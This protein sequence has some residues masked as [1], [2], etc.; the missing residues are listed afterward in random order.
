MVND[1]TVEIIPNREPLPINDDLLKDYGEFNYIFYPGYSE[2]KL[3]RLRNNTGADI[4][5]HIYFDRDEADGIWWKTLRIYP[6]CSGILPS[7][8][9]DTDWEGQITASGTQDLYIRSIC[10]K[11]GFSW[12]YE[13]SYWANSGFTIIDNEYINDNEEQGPAIDC[14]A[15]NAGSTLTLDT[16]TVLPLGT[17]IAE[18][19]CRIKFSVDAHVHLT[20]NIQYSDNNSTWTTVYTGADLSITDHRYQVTF[21]WPRKGAH[22]YWRIYKTNAAAAGGN[23]TEVQWLLFEAHQDAYDYGVY[24]DHRALMR[25]STNHMV[26][27]SW[28]TSV[29]VN[30]DVFSRQN[31]MKPI[32]K[33]GPRSKISARNF[34]KNGERI[35][36]YY[37]PSITFSYPLN[38]KAD[39][40]LEKRIWDVKAI[41]TPQMRTLAYTA[42]TDGLQ[43]S[44][45]RYD[46][47][48][49]YLEPFGPD[50]VGWYMTNYDW[51]H[52]YGH[53]YYILWDNH[54]YKV[55]DPQPIYIDDEL[56][57]FGA[58]MFLQGDM[59]LL[60]TDPRNYILNNR[61]GL[62]QQF[63]NG[64]YT[65]PTPSDWLD[66][67]TPEQRTMRWNGAIPSY[68]FSRPLNYSNRPDIYALAG[69]NSPDDGYPNGEAYVTQ[70]WNNPETVDFTTT[71]VVAFSAKVKATAALIYFQMPRYYNWIGFCDT[72]TSYDII[73]CLMQLY[74]DEECT[75]PVKMKLASI[76]TVAKVEYQYNEALISAGG[77]VTLK[78][79]GGTIYTDGHLTRTPSKLYVRYIPEDG[80]CAYYYP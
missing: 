71:Q 12:K 70:E 33:I 79:L 6:T 67:N 62:F 65:M 58:R 69:I 42:A 74:L 75:I 19:F 25:D 20:C 64:G 31:Y 5:P 2:C 53:T 78:A 68:M 23:I 24:G 43:P 26:D 66:V 41:I 63:P 34:Q 28:R 56:I 48:T 32:G 27:F 21:W 8:I 36:L 39:F 7:G 29:Q 17:C 18:E 47:R 52:S 22:R 77:L 1:I 30:I 72:N 9:V 38:A 80:H 37:I 3:I 16:Q 4:T 13:G 10:T 11:E 44:L 55:D 14:D 15:A 40:Q 61:D 51:W 76:G 35:Q 73:N 57:A 59:T 46:Q 49:I 60:G 45:W 50:K 54:C